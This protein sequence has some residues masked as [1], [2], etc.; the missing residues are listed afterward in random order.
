MIF[1]LSVAP[2]MVTWCK[3]NLREENACL[4]QQRFVTI[5]QSNLLLFSLTNTHI[6]FFSPFLDITKH[7]VVFRLYHFRILFHA[8]HFNLLIFLNAETV[9]LLALKADKEQA[10]EN[11]QKY[12]PA[13]Q[14][15]LKSYQWNYYMYIC[16]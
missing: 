6:L 11:F 7:S 4:L 15:L 12:D 10:C 9:K 3:M 1:V 13:T 5:C 14:S 2:L 8:E 16:V